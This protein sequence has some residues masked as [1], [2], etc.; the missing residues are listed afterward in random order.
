MN[1][2]FSVQEDKGIKQ[3]YRS[4]LD[5]AKGYETATHTHARAQ[6]NTRSH[7]LTDRGLETGGGGG[8]FA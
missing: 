4:V 3:M 8:V 1:E 5:D 2:S 7:F 6:E